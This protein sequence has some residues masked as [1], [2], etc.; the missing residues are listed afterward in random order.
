MTTP[1]PGPPLPSSSRFQ[2]LSKLAWPAAF[3]AT[4]AMTFAYLRDSRPPPTSEIRIEHPSPT[5]VKDL[6]SLSRL[7]T[8][9]VHLEK[10]VEVKDHQTRLHGLVE[11]DDALLFVASGEVVLG[12]DL[13]KLRE[14]DARF[15]EATKTA[16]VHLPAPEVLST[17]FDEPHSYVH[18]RNTDLLAK[19]NEALE[20]IARRDAAAAFAS[21]ASD[22]KHVERAKEQAEK[23]VRALARGWG[24][25]EVVVTWEAP[26]LI[27]SRR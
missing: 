16:Y 24:A 22:P 23:T 5:V 7:E 20:A 13:G 9:A 4:A 12:V 19:R 2:A 10:V 27:D 11:A 14:E 6:R 21:A 8:A 25:R 3:V 15:D 1:A 17:R 18:A 26:V